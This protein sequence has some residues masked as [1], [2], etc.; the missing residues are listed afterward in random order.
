MLWKKGNNILHSVVF[1]LTLWYAVFFTVAL[2]ALFIISQ[3]ILLSDLI[4]ITD[5]DL[6]INSQ[7]YAVDIK[8][9]TLEEIKADIVDDANQEGLSRVFYRLLSSDLKVIASSDLSQWENL[10]FLE[11]NEWAKLSMSQNV[12]YRTIKA[13]D[14][15]GKVRVINRAIG[16]GKYLLQIGKIV[17]DNKALMDRYQTILGSIVLVSLLCGIGLGLGM[18]KKTMEGVERVTETAQRIGKEG[19]GHRVQSG[20]EGI[21]IERLAET[22]NNMLDRIERL[23]LELRD[24]TNNVA[25]DLRTPIT[26]IRGFAEMSLSNKD[27]TP[28]DTEGYGV[29]ME[30]CNN[31]IHIINTV[32]EIAE[33]DAGLRNY[34]EIQMDLNDLVKKGYE[35]FLPVAEDKEIELTFQGPLDPVIIFGNVPRLQRIVSN[36]L[37]NALK[38]TER[39]GA[40]HVEVKTSTDHAQV[41]IRDTGLGMDEVHLKRIFEKFYRIESSRSTPGHGLGLAWVKSALTTMGASI[42]VHSVKGSG[43][44]FTLLIPYPPSSSSPDITKM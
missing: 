16:D 13:A 44:I 39:K 9:D 12:V 14:H 43:S 42:T 10:N 23:M 20:K 18:I 36:L 35:L 26:R 40:V 7:N 19:L 21:E 41:S 11:L 32:L 3:R 22:F 31:L 29:I 25:H 17:R 27:K 4:K 33:T 28:N 15:G 30:E 24:F 37:D 34:Q 38:Y 6:L 2:V 5:H 1:R 8:K